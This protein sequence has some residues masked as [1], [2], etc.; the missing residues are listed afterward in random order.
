M[1]SPSVHI[2]YRADDVNIDVNSHIIILTGIHCSIFLSIA[3][4]HST[5]GVINAHINAY[6]RIHELFR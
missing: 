5:H 4:H 1:S 6:I 3:E 2:E